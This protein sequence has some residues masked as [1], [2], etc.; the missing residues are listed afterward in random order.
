MVVALDWDGTLVES[1]GS[2]PLPGA[3]EALARLPAGTRICILSNQ[4]GPTWRRLTGDEKYPTEEQ[5]VDNLRAGCDALGIKP[6]LIFLATAWKPVDDPAEQ[7]RW[8]EAAYKASDAFRELFERAP[9]AAWVTSY[10]PAYRKPEPGMLRWVCDFFSVVAGSVLYVGDMDSD[11]TA[12][13]RA[14]CG[15]QWAAEWRGEAS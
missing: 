14:G 2:T 13:E 5:V 8:T 12:A 7:E 3:V 9:A 11:R 10:L 15:F 6:A 1:F 4:A